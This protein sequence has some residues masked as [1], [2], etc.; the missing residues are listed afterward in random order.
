M[1]KLTHILALFIGVLAFTIC[2]SGGIG[3]AELT[4]DEGVLE[5]FTYSPQQGL[6]GDPQPRQQS[7]VDERIWGSSNAPAG[8]AGLGWTWHF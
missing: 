8:G 3:R 2:L 5:P 4:S 7:T 6:T 1:I